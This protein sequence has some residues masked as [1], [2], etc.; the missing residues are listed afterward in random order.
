MLKLLSRGLLPPGVRAEEQGKLVQWAFSV[1]A[2]N[3]MTDL[4][5]TPQ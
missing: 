3:G 2:K 1:L 5:T 4:N